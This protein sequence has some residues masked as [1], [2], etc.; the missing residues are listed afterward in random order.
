MRTEKSGKDL[1][2]IFDG[3]GNGITEDEFAPKLIGKKK[4]GSMLF[5]Y[6]RLPWVKY[7][8]P[9][10]SA[11][12]PSVV[13][14][15]GKSMIK[16]VVENFG[17]VASTPTALYIYGNIGGKEKLLG[18]TKLAAIK[19]YQKE[20]VEIKSKLSLDAATDY[21]LRVVFGKG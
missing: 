13:S 2:V 14:S 15:D 8:E 16:V 19:P 7:I 20:T 3:Y 9:I 6:T 12:K 4:D 11:R 17:Q 5:G 10:L 18:Q 21:S 1:I